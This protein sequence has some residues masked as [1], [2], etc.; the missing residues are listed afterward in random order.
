MRDHTTPAGLCAG[1]PKNVC[2][3]LF[4]ARSALNFI[5]SVIVA[6]SGREPDAENIE[7]IQETSKQLSRPFGV[8]HV[9]KV[10]HY[11]ELEH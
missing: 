5:L 4:V 8:K 3:I 2:D 10:V 11:V 9:M 6:R 7:G 1:F